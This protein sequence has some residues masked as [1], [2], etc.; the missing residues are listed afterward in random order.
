MKAGIIK[1]L[2]DAIRDWVKGK[3]ADITALFPSQASSSNQ[4][5]DK[6]F[7]N[8]SVQTATANFRGVWNTWDDLPTDA[9]VYPEDYAGNRTPTVNDYLVVKDASNIPSSSYIVGLSKSDPSEN[10]T[11]TIYVNNVTYTINKGIG[12][13]GK[14]IID[15]VLYLRYRGRY[16]WDIMSPLGIKQGN[17]KI[18]EANQWY[19]FGIYNWTGS[20]SYILGGESGLYSG[21]WRCKY[22]GLWSSVGKNGWL[23]EYQVNEKPMTAAQ[24]EAINSGITAELVQKL[25]AL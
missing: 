8:S 14:A 1:D 10:A 23:P 4:L 3:L 6:A 7:V 17:T 2:I 12:E 9:N 18:A 5:A 21:T 16:W 25:I 20:F 11:V 19:N 22:T 24:V 15:G 13:A